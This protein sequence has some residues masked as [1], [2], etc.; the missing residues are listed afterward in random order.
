[1]TKYKLSEVAKQD[2]IRIHQYGIFKYGTD[3]ADKYINLLFN[4]FEV[5][6]KRP[7]SFESVSY[8]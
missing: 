2:L 7:M 3:Q 4:Y 1:M 8:I 5:I 6:V